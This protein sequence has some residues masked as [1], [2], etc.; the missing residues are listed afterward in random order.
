MIKPIARMFKQIRGAIFPQEIVVR[1][2]WE[3]SV[4]DRLNS[5]HWGRAQ[6]KLINNDLSNELVNIRSRCIYEAANNGF[7]EGVI[8]THCVDVIGCNGPSLQVKSDSE[9]YNE[10]VEKAF[11][12]W[13]NC[14]DINGVKSGVDFL[15][16]WIRQLWTHGEFLT[17][18]VNDPDLAETPIPIRLQAIDTRRLVDPYALG[19]EDVVLGVRRTKTGKPI[20]YFIQDFYD[21]RGT[22]LSA[23][24]P[25]EIKADEIIHRFLELEPGQV[26][27]VPWLATCLQSIAALRDYDDYVLEAAKIAAFY[28]VLLTCKETGDFRGITT[29]DTSAIVELERGTMSTVPP[30]WEVNQLKPEQPAANYIDYR[31]E[32]HREIGRVRNMPLMMIRLDS[33]NHNYSSARFDGQV[34]HRGNQSLQSWLSRNTL[35]PLINRIIASIEQYDRMHKSGRTLPDKPDG[36]VFSWVWPAPPHVD[37][38]KEAVASTERLQNGTS[39]LRDECSAYAKDWQDVLQQRAREKNEMESLGLTDANVDRP[40]TFSEGNTNDTTQA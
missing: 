37:P 29:A 11:N 23:Q 25:R 28:A 6:D 1:S 7:V 33:A 14:P 31:K 13:W 9:I 21:A 32:R 19:Q 38:A 40:I 30:G 36:V 16:Q 26:R 35:T 4:T 3:S 34:Y 12:D 39:T 22:E 5:A 18:I 8:Y 17:Q 20:S 24:T 2:R 15:F 10:A 27:G